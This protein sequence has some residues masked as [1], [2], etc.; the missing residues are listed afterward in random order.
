VNIA[1]NVTGD[2]C[3]SPAVREERRGFR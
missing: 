2:V 1:D 3:I